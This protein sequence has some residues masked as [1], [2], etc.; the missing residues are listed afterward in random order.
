MR[1]MQ[2]SHARLIHNDVYASWEG[3]D[4]LTTLSYFAVSVTFAV[5]SMPDAAS[6][7]RNQ[8]SSSGSATCGHAPSRDGRLPFVTTSGRVG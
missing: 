7:S 2:A 1:E 8:L 3:G 6:S 4:L 5:H